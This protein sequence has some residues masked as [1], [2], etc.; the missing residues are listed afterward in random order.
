MSDADYTNAI[1]KRMPA[2]G[3]LVLTK[4][5]DRVCA[6]VDLGTGVEHS[7]VGHTANGACGDLLEGNTEFRTLFRSLYPNKTPVPAAAAA[8][9]GTK[10]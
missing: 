7:G 9:E 3:K 4:Q 8:T 10:E 1:L 6:T 5:G 2:A